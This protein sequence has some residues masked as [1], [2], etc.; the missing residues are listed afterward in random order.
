MKMPLGA[1]GAPV[2]LV[3]VGTYLAA[4]CVPTKVVEVPGGAGGGSGDSGGT[5][6]TSGGGA[7]GG[8]GTGATGGGETN[9]CGAGLPAS[10]GGDVWSKR[11]GD[12]QHQISTAITADDEGNVVFVGRFEG[13]INFCG[14]TLTAAGESDVFV[15]K[16]DA[17]GVCLWSKQL[18]T[19]GPWYVLTGLAANA[20]GDLLIAGSFNAALSFGFSAAGK[21]ISLG[22]PVGWDIFAA[23][24]GKD[25]KPKWA[26]SIG[27]DGADQYFRGVAF[28]GFGYPLVTGR[29][30]GDIAV[31]DETGNA[32]GPV[33]S[34]SGKYDALMVKLAPDGGHELSVSFGDG[35]DQGG[36]GIAGDATGNMALVGDCLGQANFGGAPLDCSNAGEGDAFVASFY[37]DGVHKWSSRFGDGKLQSPLGVAFDAQDIV[38]TGRNQ[39]A[40]V[41]GGNCDDSV[42]AGG[43]DVFVVKFDSDGAC[44][45]SKT[46]GDSASQIPTSIVVGKDGSLLLAGY[47][48]G[49]PDFGC[50]EPLPAATTPSNAIFV[51]KLNADGACV[52]SRG[53]PDA[54]GEADGLAVDPSGDVLTAGWFEGRMDFCGG[55]LEPN[56]LADAFV[57]KLADPL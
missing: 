6:G 20:S 46:F 52:W 38:V 26:R 19:G 17:A 16:L 47:Y 11:F 7:S 31:R 14:N 10:P 30:V 15:A 13:S 9:G 34:S 28:D 37:T 50:A 18:G 45:W 5:G 8:G 39:G 54:L 2:L 41:F 57:T 51:V 4:A 56:G 29:F 22:P 55:S 23:L 36:V 44:L 35:S 48:G 43:D 25:G 32:L 12:G 3:S 49:Q 42:S 24:L 27:G 33:L 53:F 40:M 1:M 21:A